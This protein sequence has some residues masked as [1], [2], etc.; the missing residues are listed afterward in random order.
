M[1]DS[2]GPRYGPHTRRA[3]PFS[4]TQVT[5]T[6]KG[7]TQSGGTRNSHTPILPEDYHGPGMD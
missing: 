6:H 2:G 1:A 4:L 3:T 7:A 5:H